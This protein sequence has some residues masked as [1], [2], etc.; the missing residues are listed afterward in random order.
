MITRIYQGR[1]LSRCQSAA[2]QWTL[3]Q[4]TLLLYNMS[5]RVQ[6]DFV[7]E[8]T[9]RYYVTNIKLHFCRLIATVCNMIPDRALLIRRFLISK[10]VVIMSSYAMETS[11][12]VRFRTR[13]LSWYPFC[14]RQ[15]K[16]NK[17]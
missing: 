13:I 15:R 5:V 14:G 12:T 8:E 4:S 9:N 10:P 6:R 2:G 16:S 17:I 11:S 7:Y 1:L 3:S